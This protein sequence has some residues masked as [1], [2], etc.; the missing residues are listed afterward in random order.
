MV[1]TIVQFGQHKLAIGIPVKRWQIGKLC[2]QKY[3]EVVG[4]LAQLPRGLVVL[5]QSLQIN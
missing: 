4:L 5:S 3:R 2:I 1:H